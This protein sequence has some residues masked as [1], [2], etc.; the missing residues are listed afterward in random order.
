MTHIIGCRYPVYS[1]FLPLYSFWSMD[2]F[3]W[4]N[5]R[6][7][8]GEGK[9]KKVIVQDDEGFDESM[10]P[11]KK[12]SG[13]CYLT[14]NKVEPD[15]L[16][17]EYEAEALEGYEKVSH[18]GSRAPSPSRPE[19][20]ARSRAPPP[21]SSGTDGDYY[22]N[23]NLTYNNSSNPNLRLPHNLRSASGH[24][25]P[26]GSAYGG[27]PQLPQIPFGAGSVTGSDHGGYTATGMGFGMPMMGMPA[28][29][30]YAGSAYGGVPGPNFMPGAPRNSVAT[31]LNMFGGGGGLMQPPSMAELQQRPMSTFSLA[32]T[33]NPFANM[34]SQ[35]TDPTDEELLQVLRIYL[36]TQDLMTVTKK[37]VE[38]KLIIMTILPD[39]YFFTRAGPLE[40]LLWLASQRRT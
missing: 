16:S 26:A 35:S 34:P 21:P 29:S 17:L 39:P 32:T 15:S 23:T 38:T 10:I 37:C 31:N 2:D 5:T 14:C 8:I 11:L 36:S 20:R 1:F 7:V 40:K 13:M 4:G 27:L 28:Q 6:I 9:D 33:A 25:H 3:S 18:P 24:S 19:S 12:F 30:A 22:R